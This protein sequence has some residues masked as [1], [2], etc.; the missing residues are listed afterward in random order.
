[1]SDFCVLQFSKFIAEVILCK[2]MTV[3]ESKKLVLN[4]LRKQSGL[5]V[6]LN[7]YVSNT[8][9]NQDHFLCSKPARSYARHEP[10]ELYLIIN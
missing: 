7:R 5:Q 10:M 1:M 6:P 3:P 4:E 2:G 8:A 9:A